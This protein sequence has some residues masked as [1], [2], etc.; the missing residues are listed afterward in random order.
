MRSKKSAIAALLLFATPAVAQERACQPPL[1]PML[2][3]ELYF[4]QH[5]A[6]GRT[7]RD[8]DW[9]QFLTRELTPR[10]P[11]LTVVD[12]RGVWRQGVHQMREH[13][14]LVIVVLPDRTAE[15][16]RV[17]EVVDAYKQQFHQ[18]SVGIVAQPVCA[19]F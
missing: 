8:R 15:R 6:D 18:T 2:R 7:V 17:T 14:K 11:G 12:A 5:I 19:A 3:V 13:T 9:A 4:G 1:E 16:S 10:F